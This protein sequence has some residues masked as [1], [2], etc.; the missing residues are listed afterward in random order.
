MRRVEA[1]L[2]LHGYRREAAIAELTC[3]LEKHS[4]WVRI[5]T[6]S[7][8]HSRHGPV[9][10]SAVE[11]LLQRRRVR[12]ERETPGSFLADASTGDLWWRQDSTEEDTKV[13]VV[14]APKEN[15]SLPRRTLR[16]LE[17]S[18]SSLS[19]P[20]PAEVAREER[21]VEQARHESLD[22]SK[23]EAKLARS[24]RR[25]LE[26]ILNLSEREYNRDQEK[27]RSELERALAA[28]LRDDDDVD[29]QHAL[30]RSERETHKEDEALLQAI[31]LSLKDM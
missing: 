12:H 17:S 10:R 21:E 8:S 25:E 26:K 14:P 16:S 9:I 15:I 1:T 13:I 31:A 7:G 30:D 28:S 18:S 29:L 4:T 2:D 24:E 5:I 27:E 20:T 23:H 11:S 22:Q 19:G 3:F 6:G